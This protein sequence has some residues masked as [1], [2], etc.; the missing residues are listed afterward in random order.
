[1]FNV[2]RV[3]YLIEE[4]KEYKRAINKIDKLKQKELDM[5]I[6]NSTQRQ[7]DKVR[8]DLNYLFSDVK[9]AEYELHTKAVELGI[10]DKRHEGFYKPFECSPDAWHKYQY[11]PRKPD[12]R[13]MFVNNV[14]E[15]YGSANFVRDEKHCLQLLDNLIKGI[16][17]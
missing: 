6:Y 12:F 8:N 5:D 3:N 16:R 4:L 9:Q 2:D 17:K 14:R 15:V 11:T 13:K 1:M 7:R 10:A